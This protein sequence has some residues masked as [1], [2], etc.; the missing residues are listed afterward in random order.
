MREHDHNQGQSAQFVDDAN[1]SAG[2]WLPLDH[3][4]PFGP[5][6]VRAAIE[7]A[8]GVFA[9]RVTSPV[10]RLSRVCLRI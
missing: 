2:L 4:D 7:A 5:G 8:A 3:G 6:S 9:L 1:S 10:A